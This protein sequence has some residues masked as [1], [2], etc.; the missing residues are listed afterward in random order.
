MATTA[1]LCG[2]ALNEGAGT[3]L[4]DPS[5]YQFFHCD[6]LKSQWKTLQAREQDLRNLMDKADEG[7]AAVIAT[8]TYRTDYEAVL[9]EEKNLQRIAAEKKCTLAPAY[10]SDQTIR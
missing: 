5:H 7:G 3:F 4:A 8:L 10:Q 9:S 6:D 1:M 2:C